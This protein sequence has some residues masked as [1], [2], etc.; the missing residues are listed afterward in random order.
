MT[1]YRRLKVRDCHGTLWALYG[2]FE[3]QVLASFE[4]DLTNLRL[5][6]LPGAST[7]ETTAL[8]RQTLE[9][10]LDF[11]VVP[12]DTETVPLLQKRLAA[13]GLLGGNGAVI[14][15]QI[16]LGDDWLFIAADNFHDDCTVVSAEVP[17]PLLQ[18]LRLHGVL[19]DYGPLEPVTP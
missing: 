3:G 16:G 9:P 17:E 11:V 18:E 1:R 7:A 13:P 14:H 4:G 5:H 19:R 8:R 10:E 6:E 12:V 2:H 15:T